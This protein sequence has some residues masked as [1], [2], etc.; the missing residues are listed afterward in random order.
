MTLL[1]G[2]SV[3]ITSPVE[4]KTQATRQKAQCPAH[5]FCAAMKHFVL[6]LAVIVLMVIIQAAIRGNS[7]E[8]LEAS[9]GNPQPA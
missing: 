1:T 6:P 2:P 9:S 7:G 5:S 4:A 3:G 8:A